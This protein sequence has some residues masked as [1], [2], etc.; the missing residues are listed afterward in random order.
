MAD[1]WSAKTL[2]LMVILLRKRR[3]WTQA[4]L[5]EEAGTDQASISELEQ[6]K[7]APEPA[8]LR[9]LTAV[10]GARY[11]LVEALLPLLD[12]FQLGDE[13]PPASG[14]DHDALADLAARIGRTFSDAALA[15][16][17]ECLLDAPPQA[18]RA[19]A[20]AGT[21]VADGPEETARQAPSPD[22]RFAEGRRARGARERDDWA[23]AIAAYLCHESERAAA[24]DAPRALKLAHLALKVAQLLP[25]EGRRGRRAR[26]YCWGFIGNAQRVRNKLAAAEQAF[27]EARRL[28]RAA[29]PGDAAPF[30]EARILDLEASLR[31]AQRQFREALALHG[32]ALAAGGASDASWILL[33]RSATLEQMGDPEGA[34]DALRQ[35]VLHVDGEREP[36]N[37]CVLKFNLAA[38]LVDLGRPAEAEPLLPEIRALAERLDKAHDRARLRWL[39]GRVAAGLGRREEAIAI[40]GEVVRAFLD[41]E[42]PYDLALVTLDL[43]ALLAEEGRPA[44]VKALADLAAPVFQA[45]SIHREALACYLLFR[46][47]AEREEATAELARQLAERLKSSG[48]RS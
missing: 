46:D 27:A 33:N 35:A 34:I 13:G 4:K 39:E 19:G 6:A 8:R 3:W 15:I 32:R 7:H 1:W 38:S 44:E 22:R 24:D 11:P 47:A 42:L 48:G 23:S 37:L 2:R 29:G 9:K 20:P 18:E 28:W 12:R 45:E 26:A 10:T 41:L 25:K 14:L 16:L 21:P 40:L 43:A 5:A 17:T 36:R 31:R 30:S